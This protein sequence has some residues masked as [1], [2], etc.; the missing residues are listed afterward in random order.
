VLYYTYIAGLVNSKNQWRAAYTNPCARF[1]I[2]TAV[3]L[4]TKFSMGFVVV[5]LGYCFSAF[6]RSVA[7]SS[8]R[9]KWSSL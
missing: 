2:S 9:I 8:S 5:F 7:P 1:G 4:V 3:L 6:R